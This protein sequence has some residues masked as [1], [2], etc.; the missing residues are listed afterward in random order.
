MHPEYDYI[1]SPQIKQ[2]YKEDRIHPDILLS[3]D[4]RALTKHSYYSTKEAG[5]CANMLHSVLTYTL[6]VNTLHVIKHC[7]SQTLGGKAALCDACRRSTKSTATFTWS[8]IS[9]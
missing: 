7:C 1:G 5:V 2:E 4:S 6:Q 9:L 8:E 3:T